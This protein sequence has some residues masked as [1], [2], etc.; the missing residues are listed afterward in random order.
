M[1]S[2]DTPDQA[3]IDEEAARWFTLRHADGCETD[4]AAL[5]DPVQETAFRAW[6]AADMRHAETFA[7]MVRTFDDILWAIPDSAFG[8][9]SASGDDPDAEKQG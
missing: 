9:D 4:D 7:L 6:L 5:Q 3:A 8:P 2:P 1:T